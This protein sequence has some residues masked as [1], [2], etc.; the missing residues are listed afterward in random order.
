MTREGE[1]FIAGI[2]RDLPAVVAVTCPSPLSYA[3]LQPHHWSGATLCWG[4]E[5]R[6]AA[7]RFIMGMTGTR[8]GAANIEVKPIDGTSNPYL[9]MGSVLAA[10][11]AG[12]ADRLTLPLPTIE[13]PATLSEEEWERRRIRLLPG[14][15]GDATDELAA[16]SVLRKAMGDLLFETFLATRRA[17][18][19]QYADVPED[20]I[21][22]QYRWRY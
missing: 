1:A 20:E 4:Q 19:V 9:A 6:E 18:Q 10:G 8:H 14:S 21:V 12:I 11:A 3:R 2:Y 7:L 22:R 15:L 5:N 16:S 13:D 17:D